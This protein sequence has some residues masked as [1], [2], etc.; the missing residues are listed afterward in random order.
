MPDLVS[1]PSPMNAKALE[2]CEVMLSYA[3]ANGKKIDPKI[4]LKLKDLQK[5]REESGMPGREKNNI[6]DVG[7]LH[8]ML[9]AAISPATPATVLLME[10]TATASWKFLGPVPLVRKMMVVTIFCLAAFLGLFLFPEVDGTTINGDI[11]SY[12]PLAFFLNESFIV[13]SAALGASFYAL[14]EAY[15][16]IAT[17][18]YDAKY[19]SIYW[20]R[21]ILGVVSGVLLAQFLFV[22]TAQT[23]ATDAGNMSI[24]TYKPLLAFLGGFSARVVHK[25]LNSLVDSVETFISGSARDAVRAREESAR[26]EIQEK[27]SG[28][29]QENVRKES[30]A[31][32]NSVIQLMQL[33]DKLNNGAP[34]ENISN[35]L[36]AII[37]QTIQPINNQPFYTDIPNTNTNTT[38]NNNTTTNTTT[39]TN[40]DDIFIPD[41]STMDIP[42][43]FP[44]DLEQ[45]PPPPTDYK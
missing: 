19:D 5:R 30:A 1:T 41:P 6:S 35:E 40:S 22:G 9:A 42:E 18:S 37:N 39:I 38:I 7:G 2:E 16:Y 21:F 4:L 20:I 11:L 31:R 44:G 12:E 27:I 8:N 23:G 26:V 36:K 45:N 32:L 28:I 3:L 10:K 43:H 15:K 33:Q 17:S 29:Q 13:S 25:I 34:N 24:M 14:F